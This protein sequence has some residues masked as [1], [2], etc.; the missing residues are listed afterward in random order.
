MVDNFSLLL[1]HALILLAFWLLTFRDDLDSEA[2]PEPDKEP[3]GFAAQRTRR[4]GKGATPD[5]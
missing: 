3:E 2:P 4:A 1:S 5:A